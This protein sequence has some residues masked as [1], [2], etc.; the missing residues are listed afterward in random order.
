MRFRCSPPTASD[1]PGRQTATGRP[2]TRPTSLSPTGW[3]TRERP[4]APFPRVVRS[5]SPP[6][7]P[8]SR[9]ADAARGDH[10]LDQVDRHRGRR[11]DRAAVLPP[12]GVPHPLGQHGEHPAGRRLPV[13]QQGRLRRRASDPLHRPPVTAR[14]GLRGAAPGRHSDLPVGGGLDPEPGYRQAGDW[15]ARRHAANGPRQ[16]HPQ[17]PAAPG[18]L[19]TVHRQ[20]PRRP[21]GAGGDARAPA[22]ALHRPGSRALQPRHPQL[23]P[24]CRTAR[25]LLGDGGQP[26]RLA[27]QPLLG[28]PAAGPHRRAASVHLYERRHRPLPDP[29]ESAV[30]PA[31]LSRAPPPLPGPMPRC[32]IILAAASLP[33]PLLLSAQRPDSTTPVTLSPVTVS[34]ARTSLPLTKI[35]LAVQLEERAQIGRARP[36]WGLDEAL[37]AI[38][39]VYTANRYNFS[40][41]QRL[42]IR[43]FG[44]RA[45]FAVR[46]IKVLLDGI[47][48]TLPDGQ[49]QLTNLELGA[50]DRIEVLRGSASALFGNAAGGVISIW[51]DPALPP[52]L[53]EEVRFVGGRSER[54]SRRAWSKWQSTSLVRVGG[55]G[56]AQLTVSRLAYEGEREHSDADLR[57]INARVRLPVGRWSLTALADV[58]HDPRAD[59]PGA[60]TLSELLANRDS[61]AA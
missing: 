53:S 14:Q 19:R 5:H 3:S 24:D 42:S 4:G 12:R 7:S 54:D 46:G 37:A 43:G 20:P 52:R 61:A 34:V 30:A 11:V 47:P 27:R 49:G 15:R 2:R 38:P 60:L 17:R 39:G 6:T 28:L 55:G 35:P 16:H 32:M 21:P 51:T 45:A 41:D 22:A 9:A 18:T 59:N 26:R 36:T 10:Q 29:V 44:S 25:Q 50:V 48:Q 13:R 31:L 40:L 1:S 57:N 23:G 56:A 58:G 33:L 8:P